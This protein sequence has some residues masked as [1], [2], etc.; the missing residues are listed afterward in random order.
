MNMRG[1]KRIFFVDDDEQ[2]CQTVNTVL[3]KAS[4]D[5]ETF[6]N[7]SQCIKALKQRSCD[8]LITDFDL[9]EINGISLLIKA[10][11]IQPNL[12]VLIVTGYG[13]VPLAVRAVKSGADNFIEKPL[14]RKSLLAVIESVL[15]ETDPFDTIKGKVLTKTE[16]DVLRLVIDGKSNKEIA[17]ELHRS[18]RTIEDHRNHIMHKLGAH[19][20]VELVKT[21]INMDLSQNR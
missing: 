3:A 20:I 9:P 2:L 7:A 13:D 5:I 12:P 19:N 21:A 18:V 1:K 17:L 14:D 8:V 15:P 6:S 4:Y 10:K 11:R 16:M